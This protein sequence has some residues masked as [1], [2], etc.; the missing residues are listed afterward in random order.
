MCTSSSG[1]LWN[2]P[3]CPDAP[4]ADG[5]V[6]SMARQL[7]VVTRGKSSLAKPCCKS[8]VIVDP[9]ENGLWDSREQSAVASRHSLL[10]YCRYTVIQ[11]YLSLCCMALYGVEK[12][13]MKL[14]WIRLSHIMSHH[15]FGLKFTSFFVHFFDSD[16]SG[17]L[18]LPGHTAGPC[19]SRSRIVG[20]HSRKQRW[21]LDRPWS[22]MPSQGATKGRKLAKG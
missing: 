2:L 6:F 1:I 21:L 17:F 14:R 15:F 5:Q 16:S 22:G 4:M 9:G 11:Q 3:R 13:Q 12:E 10:S 7:S 8:Q 20:E 19:F 18:Q